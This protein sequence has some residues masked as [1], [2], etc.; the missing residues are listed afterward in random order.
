MAAKAGLDPLHNN[1][2]MQ[3]MRKLLDYY[4]D[5]KEII[6]WEAQAGDILRGS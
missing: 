3:K 2:V 6:D 5:N 1:P 4:R